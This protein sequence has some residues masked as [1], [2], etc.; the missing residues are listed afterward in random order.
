MHDT[1]KRIKR[2]VREWAGVAHERDLHNALSELGAQFDRWARREIDSFE[3]NDTIHRF[4][5]VTSRNIWK[6]YETSHLEPAVAAAVV[7]GVLR[8]T[9]L[10]SELLLHIAGVI[11]FYEADQ[12]ADLST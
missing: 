5:Q 3:L 7:A 11:E 1:P 4:H 2:L 9:E 12:S 10:P 6:R 8:R